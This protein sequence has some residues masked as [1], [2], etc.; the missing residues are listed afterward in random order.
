MAG[1]RA[2]ESQSAGAL[3][4][5][6]AAPR[7]EL[8]DWLTAGTDVHSALIAGPV[9]QFQLV[10]IHPFLAGNG[11]TSRLLSTPCL[12]RAGYEG[13][14]NGLGP[15]R[16]LGFRIQGAGFR[17]VSGSPDAGTANSLTTRT[18]GLSAS[19]DPPAVESPAT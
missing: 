16:G 6:P 5:Q 8:I 3:R 11:R 9:H 13:V 10:H 7:R 12:Y 19:A 18:L 2:H 14:R 15:F 1:G 4:T 17:S